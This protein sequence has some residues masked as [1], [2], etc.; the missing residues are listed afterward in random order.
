MV[1]PRHAGHESS[2]WDRKM[3][4]CCGF[5]L[6]AMA[7]CRPWFAAA[8]DPGEPRC[9]GSDINP[10]RRFNSTGDRHTRNTIRQAIIASQSRRIPMILYPSAVQCISRF[11]H[12][13]QIGPT[14]RPDASRPKRRRLRGRVCG[15]KPG[16]DRRTPPS[17]TDR[18]MR[19]ITPSRLRI[20]TSTSA[21]ALHPF[22]DH[23]RR[24]DR[25]DRPR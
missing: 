1:T 15:I 19:D 2:C 4:C 7:G 18:M 10:Q 9:A 16:M 17:R 3:L 14:H 21:I 6:L 5:R 20:P 8:D 12:N 11:S 13:T 24:G 25:R 23:D 22:A